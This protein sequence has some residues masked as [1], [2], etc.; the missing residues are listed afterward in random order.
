MSNKVLFGKKEFKYLI[1]YKDA[2]KNKP[3]C[4]FLPK[5]TAYRKELDE[6]KCI[7]FLI[8]DNELLEKYNEIWKNKLVIL[9]KNNLIVIQFPLK[10]SWEPK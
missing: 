10:N 5:M 4:I 6:T 3:L 7:S 9:S 1:G 8:K 2:K